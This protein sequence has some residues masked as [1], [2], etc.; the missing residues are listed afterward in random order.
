MCLLVCICGLLCVL[1]A[2]WP[3]TESLALQPSV[4]SENIT[5]KLSRRQL[6]DFIPLLLPSQVFH[7][8]QMNLEIHKHSYSEN[9]R[10]NLSLNLSSHGLACLSFMASSSRVFVSTYLASIQPRQKSWSNHSVKLSEKFSSGSITCKL[11]T[12]I[13][14]TRQP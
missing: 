6:I 9:T 11:Q 4:L 1:I 13:M 3:E 14:L 8:R 12:W 5:H 10:A 7:C 2:K